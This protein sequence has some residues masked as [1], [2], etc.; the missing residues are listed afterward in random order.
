MASRQKNIARRIWCFGQDLLA[1]TAATPASKTMPRVYYGG[2][3]RGYAG[4]PQVKVGMLQKAFPEKKFGFNLVYL[5]S[6]ALYLS[7]KSLDHLNKA[8]IP[9]VLN[10]N[11]VFFPAWYPKGYEKQNARLA[12][13]MASAKHVFYQS[14]FCKR[15]AD[16]FLGVKPDSYEILYNAVDT[17]EFSPSLRP[18]ARKGKQ[19][20]L[21]L[22]GKIVPSTAHRLLS[23]ILGLEAARK[24]GIDAV[25]NIYGMIDDD[26]RAKAEALAE[27]LNLH[28]SV[29]FRNPYA[30]KKAP[31][32]YRRADVYVMNKHNDSCPNTV[33]EAM[34]CGLPILY[35]ASGGTPELVGADCGVGLTV[36]ES[37]D[38]EMTPSA[39]QFAEGLEKILLNRE[40]LSQNAR[41]R[42]CTMFDLD[43]WIERHRVVFLNLLRD[44]T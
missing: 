22:T 40:T 23:T 9:I 2:A 5:L 4:G 18:A 42:A 8:N 38:E 30:R 16:L 24:G 6:G 12:E 41:K 31:D 36:P 35:S 21:L 39:V 1:R 29:Y 17:R 37:F 15:T 44:K 32:I 33:L 20:R 43:S 25:L 19:I 11:G 34:A 10:Q 28:D 13:A 7:K 14:E 26:V 3:R 27:K